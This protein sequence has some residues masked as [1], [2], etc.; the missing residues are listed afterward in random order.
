M[1]LA[2]DWMHRRRYSLL[3]IALLLLFVLQPF[4][5]PYALGRWVYDL[6]FTAVFVVVFALVLRRTPYRLA[7]LVTGLPTL[8]AT[9]TGYVL[10]GVPQVPLAV[11]FH[12]CAALFLGLTVASVL[13]A[14]HEATSVSMDSL[15]GAFG[16]Y[17][18]IGVVF[19][20]LYSVVDTLQPGSFSATTA[21]LAALLKVPERHHFLLTYYSIIT[22]TTVGYGD[23]VPTASP[24]RSLACLE[25]LVGQFYIAV[26]MAELIGLRVS[27]SR[28]EGTPGAQ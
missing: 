11:T 13:R 17:L 9:W 8:V 27:Q 5:H 28:S 14:T 16:G 6:V 4:L 10:P 20:H 19:G 15:A 18:L 24:A 12:L 3:L 7:A 2:A 25:A 26:V 1:P 22:L 21:D 23:I